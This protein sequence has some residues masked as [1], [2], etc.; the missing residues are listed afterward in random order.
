[1]FDVDKHAGGSPDWVALDLRQ[2]MESEIRN[3]LQTIAIS[4]PRDDHFRRACV[5]P[6]QTGSRIAMDSAVMESNGQM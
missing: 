3:V 2:A 1:M 6:P 5:A 4:T